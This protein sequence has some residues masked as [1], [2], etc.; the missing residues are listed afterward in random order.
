MLWGTLIAEAVCCLWLEMRLLEIKGGEKKAELRRLWR[1]DKKTTD[2][3]QVAEHS[4]KPQELQP[5]KPVIRTRKP[6]CSQTPEERL[7]ASH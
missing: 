5:C 6:S 1:S 4:E 7:P 2:A 3:Q